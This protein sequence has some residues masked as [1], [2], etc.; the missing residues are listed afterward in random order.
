MR[1][2]DPGTAC[3]PRTPSFAA[4][5][6]LAK[7]RSNCRG[8]SHDIKNR[9]QELVVVEKVDEVERDL[10]AQALRRAAERCAESY[11]I[12]KSCANAPYRCVLTTERDEIT[13]MRSK[14]R[15]M[16]CGLNYI[17]SANS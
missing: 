7:C 4:K 14:H 8:I 13:K 11:G 2:I 17:N 12:W 1:L 10:V 15:N 16:R 9:I 3:E 6:L 5:F